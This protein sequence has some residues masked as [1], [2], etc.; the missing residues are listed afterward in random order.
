VGMRVVRSGEV[1]PPAFDVVAARVTLETL[2]RRFVEL[3]LLEADEEVW[4]TL[5]LENG[6]PAYGVELDRDILPPE[7]GVVERTVD[8]AKGCYTGQEV[9]VRIR[10]RGRVNRRLRGL[11]LG[12]LELPAP[13]TPLFVEGREREAGE[14]R[15]A[16][17]SPRFGQGIAL[18]YLRREAEPPTTARLG[19]PDG[20]EVQVREI[21]DSGAGAGWVGVE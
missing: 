21:R 17:R 20:P 12:E 11:L 6:R 7:A 4:E 5:R 9:I 10:D 19:A 16:V 8:H 1:H 14:V 18:A 3:G 2:R 13:G 15:S